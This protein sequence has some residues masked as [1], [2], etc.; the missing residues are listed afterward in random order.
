MQDIFDHSDDLNPRDFRL[1]KIGRHLRVGERTKVIIGRDEGDN[2]LLEA[3]RQEGEAAITWM[4]GNTP[5]GIITGRQTPECLELSARILLRYTK[6]DKGADCRI[7]VRQSGGEQLLTVCNNLDED[8]V[9][10]YIIS[11]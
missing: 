5:V 6:A 3:A 11:L 8:A 1:L 9:K 10:G 7:S 2:G 4:D